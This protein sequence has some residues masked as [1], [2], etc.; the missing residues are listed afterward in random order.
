[1]IQPAEFANPPREPAYPDE[2]VPRRCRRCGGFL[3]QTWQ[4]E[5]VQYSRRDIDVVYWVQCRKCGQ[6]ESRVV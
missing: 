3:P 6:R 2:E 4:V 5:L 1:M